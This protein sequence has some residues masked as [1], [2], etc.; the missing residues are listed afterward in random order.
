[1]WEDELVL[2]IGLIK[3]FVFKDHSALNFA[4]LLKS[5]LIFLMNE[6]S[7]QSK[8][9]SMSL[10][11]DIDNSVCRIEIKHLLLFKNL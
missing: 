10:I 11:E 1:M 6:R 5:G 9:S 4:E 3:D 2:Y 7:L 8:W